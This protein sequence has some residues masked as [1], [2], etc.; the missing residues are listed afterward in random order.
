MYVGN[1]C[2]VAKGPQEI[3]KQHLFAILFEILHILV[4]YQLC[5][6]LPE[7][8]NPTDPCPPELTLG[9]LWLTLFLTKILHNLT[10]KTF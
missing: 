4:K 8:F 7:L 1:I 3:F 2:Y 9:V 6:F 10:I 5:S